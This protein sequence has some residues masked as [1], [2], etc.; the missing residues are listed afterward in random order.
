MVDASPVGPWTI[1]Y[2]SL[3]NHIGY[4]ERVN[5]LLK[6]VIKFIRVC[7]FPAIVVTR[8]WSKARLSVTIACFRLGGTDRRILA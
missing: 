4:N 2:K 3:R 7:F 6:N 8:L 1:L 5:H